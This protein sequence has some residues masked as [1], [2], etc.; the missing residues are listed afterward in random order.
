MQNQLMKLREVGEHDGK[1]V[2]EIVQHVFTNIVKS[3]RSKR[4]IDVALRQP[5]VEDAHGPAAF[6]A[7]SRDA[8]DMK[9]EPLAGSSS[10]TGGG[11]NR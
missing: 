5:T 2:W 3:A 10:R 9:C 7:C 8:L 1:E 4:L 11:G 6:S